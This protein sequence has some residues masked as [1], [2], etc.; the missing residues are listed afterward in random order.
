MAMEKLDSFE[1][2]AVLGGL[3]GQEAAMEKVRKV[4][5][6]IVNGHILN[7]SIKSERDSVV[8]KAADLVNTLA[9]SGEFKA[10]SVE[11][12]QQVLADPLKTE[13]QKE[14]A[15]E[16]LDVLA[17][18]VF[19]AMRYGGDTS[20]VDRLAQGPGA[21]EEILPQP[22]KGLEDRVIGHI[23]SDENVLDVLRELDKERIKCKKLGN[24]GL[25]RLA[26]KVEE[27]TVKVMEMMDNPAVGE[28]EAIM[29]AAYLNTEAERLGGG[30]VNNVRGGDTNES[31]ILTELKAIREGDEQRLA[32]EMQMF[33]VQAE[34]QARQLK[35][36]KE[37]EATTYN[38]WLATILS[39]GGQAGLPAAMWAYEPPEYYNGKGAE[40][41]DFLDTVTGWSNRVMTRRAMLGGARDIG[42]AYFDQSYPKLQERSFA[43]LYNDER[44]GL[45]KTLEFV[46]KD[47][48]VE[49]ITLPNGN[50]RAITDKEKGDGVA[51][52]F[53]MRYDVQNG[54]NQ[55]GAEIMA[56]GKKG[57]RREYLVYVKD[58]LKKIGVTDSDDYASMMASLALD[59]L[60]M[61]FGV[62]GPDHKRK[63]NFATE[64]ARTK[65]R[66][67]YKFGN[68][69][70]GGEVFAGSWTA[71][72]RERYEDEIANR[73]QMEKVVAG[74]NWNEDIERTKTNEILVEMARKDGLIPQVLCGSILDIPIG[75][76]QGAMIMGRALQAGIMLTPNEA[77]TEDMLFSINK[78][79]ENASTFWDY[80][81][82][83]T[84]LDFKG[85][86]KEVDSVLR[87]FAKDL[88]NSYLD[89]RKHKLV[90]V[91][92]LIAAIGG[93]AGLVPSEPMILNIPVSMVSGTTYS[94][95]TSTMLENMPGLVRS[96]VQEIRR[97][98]AVNEPIANKLLS[99]WEAS[100]DGALTF[101][102]R[103]S[104]RRRLLNK[105]ETLYEKSYRAMA[106]T[107]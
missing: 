79:F 9:G 76:E 100:K 65:S 68:K 46:V 66:P 6:Y 50:I 11:G 13:R 89:L 56:G 98:L 103:K 38:A 82:G 44:S 92:Q 105:P 97:R 99:W 32:Q 30:S 64:A 55:T 80:V 104:W 101:R 86:I 25:R 70:E 67:G 90:G 88:N 24:A 31:N 2:Q 45:R 47:L 107:V 18:S 69:T 28:E 74:K 63:C 39:K 87:D 15:E 85:G 19:V 8:S 62:D 75:T 10:N 1:R 17:T 51:G 29:V 3:A 21:V 57:G 73:L 33:Q 41:N 20:L 16:R 95:L 54:G 40:W 53:A 83:T 23:I 102:Q 37:A 52:I 94:F 96:E 34:N 12:L 71:Y 14:I 36:S 48:Y 84:K 93:A 61:G 77:S 72:Y 26:V 7:P 35:L 43:Q 78:W 60:E 81:S 27:A 59:F 106:E 4:T 58:N 49:T 22:L 5:E 91:D 42:K